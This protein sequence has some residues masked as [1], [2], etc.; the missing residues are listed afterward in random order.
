M[1]IE[2]KIGLGIL[3]FVVSLVISRIAFVLTWGGAGSFELRLVLARLLL[4]L[5]VI[6]MYGFHYGIMMLI[7]LLQWPLYA[8]IMFVGVLRGKA[9]SHTLAVV[10]LHAVSLIAS[11]AYYWGGA[12]GWPQPI[13]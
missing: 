12:T 11:I 2:R 6:A 9:R 7:A 13:A 3:F 4:P 1:T 5:T 10:V 8:L